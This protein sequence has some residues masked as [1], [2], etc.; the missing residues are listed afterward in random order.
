[1]AEQCHPKIK[2]S[3]PLN[4]VSEKQTSLLFNQL[5]EAGIQLA[6][7]N[8]GWGF[9][10]AA[11]FVVAAAVLFFRGLIVWFCLLVCFLLRQI[12]LH[13]LKTMKVI[14]ETGLD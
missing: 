3:V 6:Y 12:N 13:F 4:A 1:M 9:W 2:I 7:A 11:F 10:L 5:L 14:Q 8:I